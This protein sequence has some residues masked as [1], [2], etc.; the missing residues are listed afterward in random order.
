[1][2]SVGFGL[3]AIVCK[4]DVGIIPARCIIEINVDVGNVVGY[5][6]RAVVIGLVVSRRCDAEFIAAFS[7]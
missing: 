7:R 4:A 5:E 6:V 2:E 1:M 3:Y